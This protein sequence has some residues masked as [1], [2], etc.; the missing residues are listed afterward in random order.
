VKV[1]VTLK[2]TMFPAD[3]RSASILFK[4]TVKSHLTHQGK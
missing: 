1:S 2:R 3:S 4:N